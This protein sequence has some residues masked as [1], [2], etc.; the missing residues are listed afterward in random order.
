[1]AEEEEPKGSKLIEDVAR[2]ERAWRERV[3]TEKVPKVVQIAVDGAGGLLALRSD[4]T[5]WFG[6]ASLGPDMR[7]QVGWTQLNVPPLASKD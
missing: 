3:S 2:I 7:L 5:L 6:K 1:M 4:G